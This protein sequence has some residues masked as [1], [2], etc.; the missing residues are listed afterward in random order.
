MRYLFAFFCLLILSSPE[1]FSQSAIDELT[2]DRT[3]PLS[4]STETAL[5]RVHR[6]SPSGRI[7]VITNENRSF[8][9]GDFVSLVIGEK[10]IA[11]ALCAK[12]TNSGLSGIKI[13]KIYSAEL[14][15]TLSPGSDIHIIR[16]DDSFFRKKVSKKS[17]DEDQPLIQDEEDLYNET[18]LL[19]DDL[20]IDKDKKKLIKNDNLVSF[21]AGYIEGRDDLG[22]SQKYLH[23]MASW[24][25]QVSSNIWAEIIGGINYIND[26]PTPGFT[27]QMTN[28]TL[29][30]KYTYKAP[31]YTLL[32]PYAGFQMIMASSDDAGSP[33]AP[34]TRR[35]KEIEMVEDLEK[36]GPIFGLT[37]LKRLVPGWF[38]KA[39]LGSDIL[40]IGLTLEF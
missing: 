13:L 7:L 25:Y 4:S 17:E 2:E 38:I 29:K 12:D 39:D 15:K 36:N 23:Y 16:G 3:E 8:A 26:Y 9:Q 34:E 6:V 11:R 19:E 33:G 27:T 35:Q 14:F 5:E 37:V 30:A 20:L 24:A 31:F 40:S 1:I 21:S 22:D 10:I 28:L 32:Q 18:T